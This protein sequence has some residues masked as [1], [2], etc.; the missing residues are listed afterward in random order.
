[1]PIASGV[2][3]AWLFGEQFGVAKLLGAALV[4]TGLAII[5]TSGERQTQ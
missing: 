2:L 5:R 1:V 4:L 3:S